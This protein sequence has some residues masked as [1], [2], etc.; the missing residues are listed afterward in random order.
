MA[1]TPI[2]HGRFPLCSLLLRFGAEGVHRMKQA[3][4][5]LQ[6][7]AVLLAVEVHEQGREFLEELQFD[8]LVIDVGAEAPAGLMLRRRMHGSPS[9]SA[10][11]TPER[12]P[13]S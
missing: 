6:P 1:S 3:V 11:S 8:G 12:L 9:S 2:P 5:G 10:P 7:L 4:A 13:T